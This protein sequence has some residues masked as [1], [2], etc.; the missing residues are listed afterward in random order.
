MHEASRRI[1]STLLRKM[2]SF[3]SEDDE[4]LMICATNRKSDLDKAVLSRVD[5]S[6]Y[7]GLPDSMQR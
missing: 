4:T 6:I 3:E 7:F 2:D 5:V 1:L